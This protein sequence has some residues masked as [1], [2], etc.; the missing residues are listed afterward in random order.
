VPGFRS[1]PRVVGAER[2]VRRRPDG[3]A[4][5]AVVLRDRPFV[6]VLADMIEGIIV[7]NRL[8]GTAATRTRTALWE[9]VAGQQEAP[10]A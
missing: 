4:T 6:A 3:G 9:A 8:D 5:V 10:A 7:A 1:P 2:T